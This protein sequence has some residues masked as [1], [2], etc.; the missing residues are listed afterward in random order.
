MNRQVRDRGT[1]MRL[2]ERTRKLIS[3]TAFAAFRLLWP[4]L[5][6][7]SGSAVVNGCNVVGEFD[8]LISALRTA[9]VFGEDI[10]KMKLRSRRRPSTPGGTLELNRE[11]V[12]ST[13]AWL[14]ITPPALMPNRRLTSLRT[15]C[16]V[17]SP[18]SKEAR[19]FF[20]QL[21][22]A[23]L[24]LSAFDNAQHAVA[25]ACLSRVLYFAFSYYHFAFYYYY[26]YYYYSYCYYWLLTETSIEMTYSYN[27]A[28]LPSYWS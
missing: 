3:E 5:D 12:T 20:T 10:A 23:A 17:R 19:N 4:P 15:F 13:Q 22:S 27:A 26:Y 18:E 14:S 2:T 25:T 6:V 8:D 28:G 21:E 7:L 16:C 1:G 24:K 9:E 11:R